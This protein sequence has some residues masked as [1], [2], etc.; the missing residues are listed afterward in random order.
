[1]KNHNIL[2]C[3]Q[4]PALTRSNKYTSISASKS[5][6][7][8]DMITM[9]QLP[10][11]NAPR[12]ATCK[13]NWSVFCEAKRKVIYIHSQILGCFVFQSHEENQNATMLQCSK[14]ELQGYHMA[15]MPCNEYLVALYMTMTMT[16]MTTRAT[17]RDANKDQ[18]LYETA[19]NNT[20]IGR[21]WQANIG[22]SQPYSV[23]GPQNKSQN[24]FFPTKYVIPKSL[25][26][27]HWLFSN[28]RIRAENGKFSKF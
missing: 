25:K 8:P 5:L 13:P 22:K 10:T 6:H 19:A 1:M 4:A 23:K 12:L 16:T 9:S 2:I 17:K 27:S 14:Q 11:C 7:S 3:I 24:L 20:P 15:C 26:V 21:N 28:H 18:A